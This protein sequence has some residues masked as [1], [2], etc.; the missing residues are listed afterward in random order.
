LDRFVS[1]V[2]KCCLTFAAVAV[3]TC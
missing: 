1:V 3:V 2:K